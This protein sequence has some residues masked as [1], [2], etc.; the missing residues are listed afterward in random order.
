MSRSKLSDIET[1]SVPF[2]EVRVPDAIT[3]PLRAAVDLALK[4]FRR[5][6]S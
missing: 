2:A 6:A 4:E 1:R 5:K 3:F